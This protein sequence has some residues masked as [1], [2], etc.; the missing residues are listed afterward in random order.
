MKI[1]FAFA[2]SL[3]AASSAVAEPQVSVTF[4]GPRTVHVRKIPDGA[5]PGRSFAVKD[6]PPQTKPSDSLVVVERRA[7]G[8][9]SFK[10]RDG[11]TLL[12]EKGPAAFAWHLPATNAVRQVRAAR[13]A[14]AIPAGEELFG[15][16]DLENGRLRVNG[17]DERLLPAN[18]GDGIPYLVSEKG[19]A[20]FWD[21]ASSTRFTDLPG[22]S[23]TFSSPAAEA[24]DYWFFYGGD[25]DGCVAEMRKLT[26]DVPMLPLWSYG[27]CQSRERYTSQ[28]EIVDVLRRYRKDR[29]PLDVIIQDWQY[30]GDNDH[31]NAMEF[32]NPA[33]PEPKR[34]VDEIHAEHARVLISIWP[35]FGT[36]SRAYAEMD[37]RGFMLPGKS[38][39]GL[40]HD[41]FNPEARALYYKLMDP[42][43]EAGIDGWWMD[44]TDL[45]FPNSV[46][47]YNR[48]QETGDEVI[49][50]AKTAAGPFRAVRSAYSLVTVEGVYD[51]ARADPRQ[52]GRRVFILTRGACAGQ[53]R[54]G[55]AVWSGDIESN[56]DSLRK[57][58]PAG[59]S[60]SLTGNPNFNC[61]IGGFG[62]VHFQLGKP[63]ADAA[64]NPYWQELYVRWM[65]FGTFLPMMRS[66]GTSIFREIYLY[67]KPGEPA[68]EAL[69]AAVK[70]RYALMPYIY[71]TAWRC[72]AERYTMMRPLVMDFPRDRTAVRTTDE[73]MFGGA[74]L[75]A[76]V[77]E[78]A[79][80]SRE[81]HLPAGTDWWDFFTG[82]RRSGGTTVTARTTLQDIPVFVRAGSII[83][84][85]PDVQYNGE[86]P[87]DDLEVRVYPGADG[88]FTL[89]ED[90]F[91]TYAYEHG[92]CSKIRFDWN[93]AERRLTISAR[94]GAP[95]PGR[96]EKRRFR[97]RLPGREAVPVAYTGEPLAVDL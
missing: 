64:R 70:L 84:I 66:H 54:T 21:N 41:A 45:D 55:A 38:W 37:K 1:G 44:A 26:G 58:I 11:A 93:D 31:W 96:L 7:D 80:T 3:C 46:T 12:A 27:F 2:L 43:I 62:A 24:V 56:W 16:G 14:F 30:W 32:L 72:S 78:H 4:H 51:H 17:L 90:D 69:V 35:T 53:Q 67:G 91:E 74:L 94:G 5:A 8:T 95:Y 88:T 20:L 10:T 34:M 83:P 86:K 19:W 63:A 42:L 9:V 89:Y 59:C 25:A 65:Q 13:Q 6:M 49:Y 40:N 71:S 82:A 48:G 28:Q 57:Q 36:K 18:V 76:P 15:L 50:A 92:A 29:I 39:S 33:F 23:T 87:W 81:V 61:D 73:F 52:A 22:E 68:Y 60:F 85:G 47:F 77:V 97:V 75:V 79:A